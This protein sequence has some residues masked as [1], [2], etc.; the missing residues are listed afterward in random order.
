MVE[1]HKSQND[2]L[3]KIYGHTVATLLDAQF[4]FR[5]YQC[6]CQYAEGFR[7]ARMH[8]QAVAKDALLPSCFA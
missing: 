6:G 4:R 2:W 8:P 5:G 3:M 1:C 7:K